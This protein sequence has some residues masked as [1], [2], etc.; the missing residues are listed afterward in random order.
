MAGFETVQ[1]RVQELRS[2]L[3]YHSKRYYEEDAPEIEDYEYDQ[4]LRCLL[5]TSPSPRD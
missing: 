5:Y 3:N 1:K 2:L 4:M